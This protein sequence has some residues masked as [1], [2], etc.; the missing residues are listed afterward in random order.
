MSMFA[1]MSSQQSAIA[2]FY[3][4]DDVNNNFVNFGTNA[5][6]ALFNQHVKHMRKL[7]ERNRDSQWAK[8]HP[9]DSNFR[10]GDI[11]SGA[12]YHKVWYLYRIPR[13]RIHYFFGCFQPFGWSKLTILQLFVA[14]IKILSMIESS[15]EISEQ[16]N[17]RNRHARVKH[18]TNNWNE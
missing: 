3:V 2:H 6:F 18:R 11:D 10:L 16:R 12:E 14:E 9:L 17:I 13:T 15:K 4:L 5:H 7:C 8:M 1:F